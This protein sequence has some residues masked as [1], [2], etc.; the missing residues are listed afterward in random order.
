MEFN[1]RNYINFVIVSLIWK[2]HT[3]KYLEKCYGILKQ[4]KKCTRVNTVQCINT[5]YKIPYKTSI[6]LCFFLFVDESL[7]HCVIFLFSPIVSYNESSPSRR[8]RCQNVNISIGQN[9]NLTSSHCVDSPSYYIQS[10][11]VALPICLN[12]SKNIV[13]AIF[14][15]L[16]MFYVWFD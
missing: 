10:R 12:I 11:L 15:F 9:L 16:R 3:T 6:I 1:T 4:L 2:K 13:Y 5:M 7:F 14:F 8:I